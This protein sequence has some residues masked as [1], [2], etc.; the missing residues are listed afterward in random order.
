M[1]KADESDEKRGEEEDDDDD[2]DDEKKKK[3]RPALTWTQ[4]AYDPR[5]EIGGS[6]RQNI[7]VV[8]IELWHG[9]FSIRSYLE[10]FTSHRRH[11]RTIGNYFINKL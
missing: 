6:C 9:T 10:V 8:E 3:G 1:I 11:G 2:D 4:I 7:L 5:G